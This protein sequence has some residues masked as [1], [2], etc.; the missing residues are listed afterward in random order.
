MKIT[1]IFCFAFL[2]I[3]CT[4]LAQ[5][6]SEILLTI[7]GQQ[8]GTEEV[9]SSYNKN[10]DMVQ[11]E[12]QKKMDNYLELFIDYKLKTLEAYAQGL[13]KEPAYVKE[14]TRYQKQLSENYLFDQEITEEL[15]REAYDRLR[16][17]VNVNHILV[18]V[19]YDD[20]P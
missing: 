11:D 14:F 20:K 17:E 13:D 18:L 12:E 6:N 4:T 10:L 7:N 5:K 1:R 8:I 9:L 3:A 16:E 2:F 19:S 15:I